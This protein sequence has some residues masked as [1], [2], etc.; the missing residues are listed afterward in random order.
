[1]T[2]YQYIIRDNQQMCAPVFFLSPHYSS[3]AECEKDYGAENT[4][5]C[6]SVIRPLRE[7][8]VIGHLA[9][10]MTEHESKPKK[11]VSLLDVVFEAWK[12]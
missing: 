11:R 8:K 10:V 6:F 3:R 2:A 5:C 12:N 9:G 7:S 4:E 1:M